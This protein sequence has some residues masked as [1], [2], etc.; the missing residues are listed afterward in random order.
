MQKVKIFPAP[1]MEV[2]IHVSDEMEKDLRECRRMSELEGDEKDCD[3]CSW[4]EV[5][6]LDR[7]FCDLPAVRDK[8]LGGT[9]D[10]GSN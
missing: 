6:W 3:S 4:R 7:C 8:I 5:D 10:G 1:H 9:R 2:R